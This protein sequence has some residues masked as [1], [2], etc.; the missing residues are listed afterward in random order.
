MV[1]GVT[2]GVLISNALGLSV[3]PMTLVAGGTTFVVF[4]CSFGL[5]LAFRSYRG[6]GSQCGDARERGGGDG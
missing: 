6:K 5:L 3:V 2:G 1:V 4:W